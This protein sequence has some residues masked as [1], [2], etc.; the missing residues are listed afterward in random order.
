MF[1]KEVSLYQEYLLQLLSF[2]CHLVPGH[3]RE[4]VLSGMLEQQA[5]RER[6]FTLKDA[7]LVQI[8]LDVIY[9]PALKPIVV[10]G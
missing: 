10:S 5:M 8:V 3:I 6:Q 9:K 2:V 7:D 4:E 1:I